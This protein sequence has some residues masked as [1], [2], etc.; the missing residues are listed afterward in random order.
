MDRPRYWGMPKQEMVQNLLPRIREAADGYQ[1]QYLE[2]QAELDAEDHQARTRLTAEA[3]EGAEVVAAF[4]LGYEALRR[5]DRLKWIHVWSAGVEH[6]LYP[7]MLET[8]FAITAA[9]G[10]GGIPMAEFAMTIMLTFAKNI[11]HF[12]TVQGRQ[13]WK[14]LG[15]R[16]LNGLTVGIIGLGNSGADLAGK[17]KAFHMRVLGM[18]RS[19]APC[20]DVDEMYARD[21]LPDMLAQCDFVVVTT[22]AT[23]ETLGMLGEAEFRAMKNSAVLVVTSRGGVADDQALLRALNEGWIA[24]AGLDAHTTEPLPADSPFWRAPNTIVTPHC[25]AGGQNITA[26]ME[27]Q[28]ICNIHRYIR[29]EP[30]L[31]LVDRRAAY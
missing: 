9:K 8:E 12:L 28:F 25:A 5:A 23:P 13:E 3:I 21:Q 31:G 22:P 18:R 27:D 10:S 11:R 29:G 1:V 26:R 30:L 7:E 17:C 15:N 20:P 16:E 4:D 6:I 19:E 24:G 2:E 14:F